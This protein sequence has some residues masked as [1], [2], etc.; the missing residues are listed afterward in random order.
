MLKEANFADINPIVYDL[1]LEIIQKYEKGYIYFSLDDIY[2]VEV[3]EVTDDN[4]EIV[5]VKFKLNNSEDN[6][7]SVDYHPDG[8]FTDLF[9]DEARI[10]F[11][12]QVCEHLKSVDVE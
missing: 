9:F 3:E 6:T 4:D 8:H 12:K 7:L 11:Y 1:L 2:E 5:L 10:D